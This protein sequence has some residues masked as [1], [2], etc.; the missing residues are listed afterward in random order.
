MAQTNNTRPEYIRV[1]EANFPLYETLTERICNT[2]VCELQSLLEQGVLTSEDVDFIRGLGEPS[3]HTIYRV[4]K[5]VHTLNMCTYKRPLSRFEAAFSVTLRKD[6]WIPRSHKE[7]G[8]YLNPKAQ[9]KE[10]NRRHRRVDDKRE[11]AEQLALHDELKNYDDDLYDYIIDSYFDDEY[12]DDRYDGDCLNDPFYGDPFYDDPFY[13]DSFYGDSF[14]GDSF[15]D[16]Y[17]YRAGMAYI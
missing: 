1:V 4:Y 17:T 3:K 2:T 5:Y 6:N 14:Y 13:G 11:I 15:S 7:R 8:G 10:Q 16:E 12:N 9:K